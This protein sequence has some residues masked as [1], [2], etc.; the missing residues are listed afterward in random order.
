[1]DKLLIPSQSIPIRHLLLPNYPP[2]LVNPA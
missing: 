2:Y 1:M